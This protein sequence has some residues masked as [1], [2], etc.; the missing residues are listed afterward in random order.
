MC[1]VWKWG[2]R[3]LIR[4]VEICGLVCYYCVIVGHL[5]LNT[6][7]LNVVVVLVCML[8]SMCW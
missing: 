7:C 6:V 8:G 1:A 2:F 3:G 4:V 5:L